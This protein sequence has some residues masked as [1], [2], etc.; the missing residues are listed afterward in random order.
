MINLADCLFFSLFFFVSSCYSPKQKIENFYFFSAMSLGTFPSFCLFQPPL[1]IMMLALRLLLLYCL[2]HKNSHSSPHLQSILINSLT[3]SRYKIPSV[4]RRRTVRW[5][6]P[7]EL[8]G[9]G[10]FVFSVAFVPTFF[11]FLVLNKII[12]IELFRLK[13]SLEIIK[14]NCILVLATGKSTWMLPGHLGMCRYD[15][16]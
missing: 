10:H 11:F 15:R 8:L 2:E 9:A 13:K 4:S 7:Q 6:H 16:E 5:R 14:S 1:Y 12:F 3:P